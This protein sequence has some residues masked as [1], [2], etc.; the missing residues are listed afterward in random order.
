MNNTEHWFYAYGNEK[1]QKQQQQKK[2]NKT[3]NYGFVGKRR[4]N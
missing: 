2:Q 4:S 1:L 3:K